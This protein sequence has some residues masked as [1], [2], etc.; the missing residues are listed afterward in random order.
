M[1]QRIHGRDDGQAPNK[2]WNHTVSDKII[3][4]NVTQE[5][6]LLELATVT[7]SLEADRPLGAYTLSNDVFNAIK[8]SAADKQYVCGIKL[9]EL[10]M[11]MFTSALTRN[12]SDGSFNDLQESL[13]HTLTT[14]VTCNGG[15][16]F[17]LSCSLIDL[18]YVDNASRSTIQV[19]IGGLNQAK[20]NVLNIL[21][22][23]AC[24]SKRSRVGNTKRDVK[25]SR[26]RLCHQRLADASGSD[27][28]D[29]ALV[30][31]DAVEL[32]SSMDALVVIVD[33]NR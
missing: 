4:C 1:I 33:R 17:A 31:L 26:Q 13:L 21:T 10:I 24:L 3:C 27:N 25:N 14:D 16:I 11:R 22:H 18:I 20:Q 6:D 15:V 9:N 12:V 2:F 5:F 28:E 7:A 32:S 8:R 29:I 19:K 30:Y 23:I